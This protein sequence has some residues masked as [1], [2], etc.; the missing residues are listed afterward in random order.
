MNVRALLKPGFD[1][2]GPLHR[3]DDVL[4]TIARFKAFTAANGG[5]GSGV[6]N[7]VGRERARIVVVAADGVF[8]DA[9]VSSVEVGEQ[10][11]VSAGLT[12]ESW[13]RE[14]NARITTSPADRVKMAGT[15]R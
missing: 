2:Q 4:G 11:C 14:L 13:N 12:V 10:I 5:S 1:V 3:V 9:V 7:Y 8:T 15:G 6:V